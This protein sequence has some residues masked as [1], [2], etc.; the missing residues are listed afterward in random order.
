[1]TTTIFD[2]VTKPKHYNSHPS[3]VEVIE[4][5]KHLNF[6]LG[7]VVKYV[8]RCDLK[9]DGIEDLQKARQYLDF[10][11]ARRIDERD[12]F[13]EPLDEDEVSNLEGDEDEV[14]YKDVATIVRSERN[15]G[16]KFIGRRGIVLEHNVMGVRTRM[17]LID[18]DRPDGHGKHAFYWET[19]DLEPSEPLIGD[20]IL[21]TD[22]GAQHSFAEVGDVGTVVTITDGAY[23]KLVDVRIDRLPHNQLLTLD[24]LKVVAA[25]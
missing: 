5:T 20:R 21:V 17:R 19:L 4:I 3:G 25:E 7:N 15:S 13:T 11:L 18:G 1:M 2:N 12:T 6:C 8:L 9:N 24:E 14:C 23:R 22:K 16:A 10:E